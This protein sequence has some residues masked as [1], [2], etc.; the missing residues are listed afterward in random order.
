MNRRWDGGPFCIT[1]GSRMSNAVLPSCAI[2]ISVVMW[3][4]EF[5][6]GC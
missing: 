4:R 3:E 5:N 2:V 1:Y 6:M